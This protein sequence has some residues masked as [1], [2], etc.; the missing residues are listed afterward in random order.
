MAHIIY[1][2]SKNKETGEI[3]FFSSAVN[4]RLFL[5]ENNNWT[6][7]GERKFLVGDYK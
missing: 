1:Y 2:V 5:K 6:G 3:K 4:L 7:V